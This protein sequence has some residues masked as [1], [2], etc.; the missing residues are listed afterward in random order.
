MPGVPGLVT[1]T[2]TVPGVAIAEPGITTVSWF[3]LTKVVLVCG[4]PFQFIVAL[5]AKLLPL[6]VKVNAGP[7]E[8]MLDGTSWVIAGIAPGCG[9]AAALEL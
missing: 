1:E 8:V 5:A 4:V 3:A 7:P 2:F 6:T 9:G